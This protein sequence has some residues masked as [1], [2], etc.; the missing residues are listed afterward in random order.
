MTDVESLMLVLCRRSG[1][2]SSFLKMLSFVFLLRVFC[3]FS[4]LG[5]EEEDD[6]DDENDKDEEEE[7]ETC[8]LL[9]C[10]FSESL[11]SDRSEVTSIFG[12]FTQAFSSSSHFLRLFTACLAFNLES[13][14]LK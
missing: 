13:A 2:S 9:L 1:F 12:L 4:E 5:S 7:H 10:A 11:L 3:S 14:Q 8:T 6:E